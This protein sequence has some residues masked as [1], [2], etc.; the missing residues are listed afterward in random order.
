MASI[1]AQQATENH[2]VVVADGAETLIRQLPVCLR[3]QIIAPENVR[4]GHVMLDRRVDR[5]TALGMLVER[6]KERAAWRRKRFGRGTPPADSFD[7]VLNAEHLDSEQQAEVI[8]RAAEMRHL[9]ELGFLSAEA[10]A[11]L[12]FQLRLQLARHGITRSDVPV[13][14]KTFAHP[15]EEVFANLLNFYQIAWEYEPRTFALQCDAA[16]NPTEA[17]TPDFYLP[18]FDMYVELTTMKQ[19]LVTKKN[20]KVK[21]LKELHPEINIQVFYQKDFENLIF[22]YGLG[23]RLATV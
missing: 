9:A 21:R 7:V 4:T 19:S 1:V 14:R 8:I 17:F 5:P 15:S 12:Q 18:E 13:R 3:V 6:D 23:E 11:H 2:L 16:G 22:K 20:R 10:E